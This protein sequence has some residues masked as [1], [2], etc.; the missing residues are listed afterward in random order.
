MFSH[1]INY[2]RT[3]NA[4]C[5]QVSR[6]VPKGDRVSKLV[7]LLNIEHSNGRRFVCARMTWELCGRVGGGCRRP[8][9]F[10][11]R[12]R[13]I[14]ALLLVFSCTVCVGQKE[15]QTQRSSKIPKPSSPAAQ[16]QLAVFH[17]SGWSTNR[18]T[19][20][21]KKFSSKLST[22]PPASSRNPPSGIILLLQAGLVSVGSKPVDLIGVITDIPTST[23]KRTE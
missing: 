10:P 7:L 13:E 14:Y 11:G 20:G 1:P 22:S 8:L 18:A 15:Q 23:I 16:D 2:F 6:G 17:K 3:P 5:P 21:S 4:K 19:M 12:D 9:P